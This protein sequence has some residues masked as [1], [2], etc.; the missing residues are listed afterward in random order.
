MKAKLKTGEIVELIK[1]D[2]FSAAKYLN[3]ETREYVHDDEI[4]EFIKEGD[5][6][7]EG[8]KA[9]VKDTLEDAIRV[10]RERYD[11]NYYVSMIK[12]FEKKLEEI[13]FVPKKRLKQ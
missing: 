1:N 6:Y 3:K 9:G 2:D 7:D 4:E 12:Y 11:C 13:M 5:T 8:Y 10:M